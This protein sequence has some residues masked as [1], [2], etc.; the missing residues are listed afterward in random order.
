MTDILWEELGNSPQ[1]TV[2]PQGSQ[3]TRYGRI[4]W[5]DFDAL[6]AEV[7]PVTIL[8][9]GANI[10]GIGAPMPERPYLRASQMTMQPETDAIQ[11]PFDSASL[12]DFD[13]LNYYATARV[14][15]QYIT[16]KINI[17]AP[18][19]DPVPLLTHRWAIG[20]ETLTLPNKGLFWAIDNTAVDEKLNA[21]ILIPKIE[22]QIS[23]P[24]VLDPPFDG[25]RAC[26]GGVNDSTFSLVTGDIAAETLLFLGAELERECLS[27]GSRAWTVTYRFSEKRLDYPKD[28]CLPGGWNHFWDPERAGFYRMQIGQAVYNTSQWWCAYETGG[29]SLL[30]RQFNDPS[31]VNSTS[32]FATQYQRSVGQL[33]P[34]RGIIQS[35]PYSTAGACLIGCLAAGTTTTPCPNNP[36]GETNPNIFPLVDFNLLFPTS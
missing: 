2:N 28:Q 30:D 5:A 27:D 3:A 11:G 25:I 6:V 16:P 32:C 35:G 10:V 29:Q 31:Y 24:H 21:G 19:G 8:S 18:D 20:A 9:G 1:Y 22:H 13:Q 12:Q 33:F 15:I 14:T 23:W 17:T 4:N 26:M 34:G 7:F 36:D